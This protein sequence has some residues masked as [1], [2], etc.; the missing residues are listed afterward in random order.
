MTGRETPSMTDPPA[1]GSPGRSAVGAWLQLLR[2]PN[3]FTVPGDPIAGF[4]LAQAAGLSAGRPGVR[5]GLAVGV[6]L[7][8]YAAGLLWND[9]FDLGEDRRDR[10]TRPL[11]SG[12]VSCTAVAVVANVLMLLALAAAAVAGR[13]TLYAAVA[14]GAAV[15]AYDGFVKRF[16]GLGPLNM[17][18]CRGVSLLVGA[19]AFGPAGLVEPVV[20]VSAVGLTLY[21]AAVTHLAAGETKRTAVRL[22]VALVMAAVAVWYVGLILTVTPAAPVWRSAM[23]VSAA[24]ATIYVATRMAKLGDRPQPAVVQRTV[25]AL[26][27]G[28]VLIQATAVLSTGWVGV[29]AAGGLLACFALNALLARRFYAS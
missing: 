18:L 8:L 6:S 29:W 23:T 14:L 13:T 4:L 5:V 26:I 28:L 22:K 3:L 24:G 21:I 10:P 27:R 9:W 12:Q 19:A 1:S 2:V 17:G 7:L 15:L 25:G 11:P 20:I 16:A